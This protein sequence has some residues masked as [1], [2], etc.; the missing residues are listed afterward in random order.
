MSWAKHIASHST[1]EFIRDIQSDF[2]ENYI[3]VQT[4]HHLWKLSRAPFSSLGRPNSMPN[5]PVASKQTRKFQFY[6][7]SH[8]TTICCN[9][10][11][12]VRE[13]HRKII[14]HVGPNNSGKTHHALHALAA[15]KYGV[16]SLCRPFRFFCTRNLG[17]T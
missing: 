1:T 8:Q 3:Y 2:P 6:T 13:M 9:R 15:A 7:I 4:T 12:R 17:T 10:S 16:R 5:I 11:F 14:M